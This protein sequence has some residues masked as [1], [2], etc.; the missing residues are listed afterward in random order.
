MDRFLSIE[1]FVRVADSESFAEAARQLRVSKSV[2][3]S[4]VRQLEDFVGAPLFH[5]TTRNVHLSEIGQTFY[6]DCAELI[7]RASE[8]V[9]HMRDL[10]ASPTGKL[11]VHALPGFVLGR[12][13]RVLHGFQDRY[14]SLVLDLVVDDAVIDPVKEGFDC[15]LQIFPPAS[16]ELVERRLFPVR[17]VFC[18]SP[19]YLARCSRLQTPHELP[20]H[21]L[22]LYSRYPTRDRW[23]FYRGAERIP[24]ELAPNLYSNS[25]Q[26]LREFALENSGVVCIPTLVA[27]DAILDGRLQLVLPDFVLS[28]FWLSAVFPST[29]R[30]TFKLRL[31]LDSLTSSFPGEPPW[32]QALIDR[33]LLPAT[34]IG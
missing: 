3:T 7:G 5:R 14:P 23:V 32:D 11:R 19:K 33:G 34:L 20:G 28:S 1:A 18:A 15:T 31:F 17:R 24:I 30:S 12:L 6:R 21:R 26:L 25:V 9:D 29:Q 27:A 22:G 8:L 10:Q 4:R 16:E 13:A 2:I